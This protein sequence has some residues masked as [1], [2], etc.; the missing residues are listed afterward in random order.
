MPKLHEILAVR[1]DVK[2]QYEHAAEK[3]AHSWTQLT[4]LFQGRSKIFTPLIDD[5]ESTRQPDEEE[6]V[7]EQVSRQIGELA[8]LWSQLVD[9][10]TQQET[11]N[12]SDEAT[13][14]IEVD[15]V[16]II[17]S[18]LPAT[19]LLNLEQRLQDLRK[20]VSAI[21]VNNPKIRWEFNNDL[22][23]WVSSPQKTL[24][25]EKDSV[26]VVLYHATPEHPAQTEMVTKQRL[27]GEYEQVQYSGLISW[28]IKRLWLSRLDALIV[29]T[30]KARQ[31]ANS[32][33]VVKI[34]IGDT[35][36]NYVFGDT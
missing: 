24:K 3:A 27:V 34:N 31:R 20:L 28:E 14:Y 29:A 21:P 8:D 7:A 36:T 22:D 26:P 9:A 5:D 25:Y 30:K 2:R 33:E 16:R 35:I 23:L 6:P 4:Q 19:A 17:E 15:G 13:A 10:I 12:A 1:P 32:A 18:A 11:T